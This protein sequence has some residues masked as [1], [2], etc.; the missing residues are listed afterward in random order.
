MGD[1]IKI[2]NNNN[3]LNVTVRFYIPSSYLYTNNMKVIYLL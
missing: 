3:N 1:L 2:N